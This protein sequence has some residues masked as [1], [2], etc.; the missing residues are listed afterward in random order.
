MARTHA[1]SVRD[2]LTALADDT[3]AFEVAGLEPAERTPAA[4]SA[5]DCIATLT[6]ANGRRS[7]RLLI[8]ARA[9]LSPRDALAA[10]AQLAPH[11]MAARPVGR[12]HEFDAV[13]LACPYISPR[14]AEICRAHGVGYLDQAGNCVVRAGGLVV[15]IDGRPN[16]VPDTRPLV[17][18]F[19]PKA[20]RVARLLLEQPQ[21]GWQVQ[22]L[23]RAARI[24]LGLA[25]RAKHALLEQ[26]YAEERAGR[27]V[28]RDADALLAAWVAAYRPR[29]RRTQLYVMD[30][31]ARAEA[32]AA[33]WCEREGVEYG[34]A[35]Y[36][37][38][39]RL[40]PM[41]RYRQACVCVRLSASRDVLAELAAALDARPAETGSNVALLATDDEAV[42]MGARAVDGVR[43]LAPVQLYLDLMAQPGRGQEAA[44]EL[45]RRAL[46]PAF[47]PPRPD[48]DGEVDA[49]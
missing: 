30:E 17:G 45:R 4:R 38:A 19:S 44:A 20:S 34:L 23:A 28:L 22:E 36:S 2:W 27:V 21:R 10:C 8:V 37:G 25:S 49:G 35:E 40:A 29:V 9:R 48:T 24:S 15:H 42:F 5:G 3:A 1:T 18:L 31:A 43:V 7:V 39:W 14:V 47:A 33:A 46:E 16:V 12:S 11:T 13:V 32:A 26:G 41:V 6:P